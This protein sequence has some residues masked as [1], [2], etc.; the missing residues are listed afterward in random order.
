MLRTGTSALPF[1]TFATGSN[2]P[3]ASLLARRLLLSLPVSIVLLLPPSFPI[4]GCA[5]AKSE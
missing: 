1:A 2:E 3:S 5:A 4:G